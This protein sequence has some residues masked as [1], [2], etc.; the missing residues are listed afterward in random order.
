LT[1]TSNQKITSQ[2]YSNINKNGLLTLITHSLTCSYLNYGIDNNISYP[3]SAIPTSLDNG[4]IVIAD[5]SSGIQISPPTLEINSLPK[6]K[7]AVDT[8]MQ[9]LC[10]IVDR[11]KTSSMSD[12]TENNNKIPMNNNIHIPTINAVKVESQQNQ[13]KRDIPPVSWTVDMN[14]NE[15][16]MA[17]DVRKSNGIKSH[18]ITKDITADSSNK[19]NN[20]E[21]KNNNGKNSVF[22]NDKFSEAS[23]N[24]NVVSGSAVSWAVDM[25]QPPD[26]S[27]LK[28]QPQNP[29]SKNGVSKP[30]SLQQQREQMKNTNMIPSRQNEVDNSTVHTMSTTNTGIS[31]SKSTIVDSKS[32]QGN[33]NIALSGNVISKADNHRVI[34][35]KGNESGLDQISPRATSIGALTPTIIF[36]DNSPLRCISL[37]S[38]YS[39]SNNIVAAIGSNSKKI[40]IVN[41]DVSNSMANSSIANNQISSNVTVMADLK[42]IH[43]G[44]VYSCD[45]S[46]NSEIL[47]SGSNDK[48]IRLIR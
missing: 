35:D 41:I 31:S 39:D 21:P 3:V 45:W 17:H 40:H 44:S 13:Q 25:A 22:D 38:A 20:F 18:S 2:D 7:V 29:A 9:P 23:S 33:R 34:I 27:N 30:M 8:S 36:H 19:N 16:N 47:A 46:P 28:K 24:T 1:Q 37:S 4:R 32:L 48:T 15:S 42:D 26:N 14:P 5:A 6:Y 11:L 10:S 12:K 43:N